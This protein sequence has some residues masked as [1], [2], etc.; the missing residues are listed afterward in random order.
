VTR[1]V[2]HRSAFSRP[3]QCSA[4]GFLVGVAAAA[5]GGGWG[6]R[7][8]GFCCVRC[9]EQAQGVT[10][11]RG[12]C[13]EGLGAGGQAGDIVGTGLP[14][15]CCCFRDCLRSSWRRLGSAKRPGWDGAAAGG[16]PHAH[17]AAR[18]R[19]S[20]S[21]HW[22]QWAPGRAACFRGCQTSGC[23]HSYG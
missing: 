22:S 10:S 16:S 8:L 7:A 1:E 21:L 17:P 15:S 20:Q 5:G 18:R 3:S 9:V 19:L 23:T 11:A 12:D 6:R 13:G 4:S 2:S 14:S